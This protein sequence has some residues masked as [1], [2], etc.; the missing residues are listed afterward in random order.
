[1][2]AIVCPLWTSRKTA[3]A[4]SRSSRSVMILL[5][6]GSVALAALGSQPRRRDRPRVERQ[7]TV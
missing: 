7:E 2:M 1:V 6:V 3:S 4:S 5:I